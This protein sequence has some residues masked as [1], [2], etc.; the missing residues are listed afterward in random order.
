MRCN[1]VIVSLLMTLF[2]SDVYVSVRPLNA[3]DE[4]RRSNIFGET[5]RRYNGLRILNDC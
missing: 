3:G 2:N 4:T 5:L 1:D